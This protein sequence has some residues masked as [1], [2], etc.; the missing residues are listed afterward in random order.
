MGIKNLNIF[1]KKNYN[2]VFK[3]V[4]ITKLKGHKIALDGHN[5]SYKF[6]SIAHQRIN[7]S[8]DVAKEEVDRDLVIKAWHSL[9]LGFINKLIMYGIV[10]LIVFDGEAPEEKAKTKEGRLKTKIDRKKKIEDIKERLKNAD[11]LDNSDLLVEDLKKLTKFNFK[12]TRND[13]S[14]LKTLLKMTGLPVFTSKSEGEKLCAILNKHGK[15]SAVFT[16][17]T[18]TLVYGAK[19]V[20][21][22]FEDRD[23]INYIKLNDVLEALDIDFN[24]FVE[25]SIMSGCDYNTNIPKLSTG[26]AYKLLKKYKTLNEIPDLPDKEC[27]N[28]EKCKSLF[29]DEEL[30]ENIEDFNTFDITNETISNKEASECYD[31][32]GMITF[33]YN[34][35]KG[36]QKILKLREEQESK[37]IIE[38]E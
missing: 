15:C 34:I 21:T 38:K 18:D 10:P 29:E 14:D 26:K 2:D 25:L 33:Y 9:F 12:I 3:Q 11:P 28:Y 20:I 6:M 32:I 1:L 22:G 35:M 37:I 4:S 27:L 16:T 36:L 8:T 13:M 7:N 17:D 31:N 23:I 30:F 24:T 5:L 19:M